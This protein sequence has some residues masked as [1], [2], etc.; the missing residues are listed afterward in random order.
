MFI[1][2]VFLIPRFDSDLPQL[3]NEIRLQL[4]QPETQKG[5]DF[6]VSKVRT[7][8]WRAYSSLKEHV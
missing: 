3:L 8:S 7:Y 1:I 5:Y 6:F 2:S 4:L